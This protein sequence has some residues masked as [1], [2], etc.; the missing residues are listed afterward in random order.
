[1]S[2]SGKKSP[3]RSATAK[4][5]DRIR[6]MTGYGRAP[7]QSKRFSGSVETRSFNHRH[8]KVALKTPS[9]LSSFEPKIEQLIRGRIARGSVSLTIKLV[10]HDRTTPY[11]FDEQVIAGYVASLEGIRD[12]LG[13][14]GKPSLELLAGLPEALVSVETETSLTESDWRVVR[15]GILSALDHL[16]EMRAAEGAKL[17]SDVV[18]RRKI[19][20]KL[21][22]SIEKVAPAVVK[23]YRDRLHQR[24]TQ[25]LASTKK[26][27][28]TKEDLARE[29]ALFADRCDISE[30][31]ARLD[32][33]LKQFDEIVAS[34]QE[35]GRRL[36]FI[37]HEMFR[38]TNT[39]G[40]KSNDSKISHLVVEIKAEIEK[41]RE[42]VQNIE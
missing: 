18:K 2:P 27:E 5:G 4:A 38:E 3:K 22:R 35:A 26:V 13:L 24:I 20:A 42:Q 28:V 33:H 19:I 1:M 30:E 10:L 9:Y 14:E 23:G 41:I 25:L 37:L 8:L 6:S 11:Q 12:K 39:I 36:E 7:I 32:S 17:E 34:K 21:V 31:L 15:Q 40:S 16:S 29:V